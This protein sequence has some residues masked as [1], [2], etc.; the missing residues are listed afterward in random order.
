LNRAALD[1]MAS[2]LPHFLPESTDS[3]ED[4]L[5]GSLFCNQGVFL[6]D[7]R[8][9]KDGGLRFAGSAEFA[10]NYRGISPIAPKALLNRFNFKIPFGSGS[11]SEQQISFH[12][13]DRQELARRGCK[14]SD[15]MYRYD[16]VLYDGWCH[17]D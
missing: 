1:I 11:V 2:Q 3:R 7:T 12:L 14:V 5:V 17:D 16:S 15:L 13:G 6:T 10:A 4:V 8:H 9:E